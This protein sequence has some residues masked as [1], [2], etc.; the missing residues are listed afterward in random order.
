MRKKRVIIHTDFCKTNSGFGRHSK[1]ILKHLYNTGKYELIEYCCGMPWSHPTFSKMPWKSFGALPDTNEEWQQ[2]MRGLNHQD[3]EIKKREVAYG[4]YNIDRIIKQEQPDVYIGI[5]DVWAFN[6]YFDKKWWNQIKCVVHTTLDSLP[7]L[8][9]AVIAANKIKNYYVWAGFA[10][11]AMHELG[12]KHVKLMHGA[13]ETDKFYRLPDTKKRELRKQFNIPENAFVIGFVFRNQLRKG[14][15]NL[16][17]GFKMFLN[18]N[19]NSNAYLLLHTHFSEGWNIPDHIKE[20]GID[21][22]RV[23][24]TY[25][26]RNCKKYEI[27]PFALTP[28]DYKE[29]RI[30]IGKGQNQTCEYCKTK[31]SQITVNT[32]DGVTEDELNEIY[33]LMDVYTGVATSGGQEYPVQESKLT[34]LITCVTNYSCG[35]DWCGQESGG[36]PLEYAEFKEI[37]TGF[38]KASTYP[39]SIAKQLKKVFNMKLSERLIYGKKARQFVIDTC[40]VDIVGKEYEKI[41][42]SA[43]FI[44]QK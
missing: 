3:Q 9:E 22:S 32:T 10:E 12:H 17:E 29:P 2:I 15:V 14:V 35:E 34:E 39:S 21:P 6:G 19:P 28:E 27:K 33:N 43:P 31:G 30:N 25:I 44:I 1:T 18:E 16:L 23:L 24:C 36:I 26:C 11:K 7:I 38:T 5:N 13:L 20:F 41:I 42:D 8:P 40:S 4:S 37:G